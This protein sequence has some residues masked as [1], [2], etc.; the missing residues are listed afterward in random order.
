MKM[1]SNTVQYYWEDHCQ[2]Q[3]ENIYDHYYEWYDNLENVEKTDPVQEMINILEY[4]CITSESLTKPITPQ[5]LCNHKNNPIFFDM[6]RYSIFVLDHIRKPIGYK[7]ITDILIRKQKDYGPKNIMMFGL[8]GIIVRMYDK[9]A[10]LE[11]L[12]QKAG[13]NIQNA[14]HNNSVNGETLIDTLI[15]I[16]GYSTIGLMIIDKDETHTNKFLTPMK[17]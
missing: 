1:I 9:I 2:K 6:A 4:V 17:P 10:R 12:I 16:I 13:G 11:N 5:N 8:T 14:T 7:E 15:D 3:V